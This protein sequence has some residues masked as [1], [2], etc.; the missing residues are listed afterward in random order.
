MFAV[1]VAFSATVS[2]VVS[3]RL[4]R[5]DGA[6]TMVARFLVSFAI[7]IVILR[8]TDRLARRLLPLAVLWKLSLAFP[9]AAPSR[10][11]LAR[12][13]ANVA[14]LEKIAEEARRHG[15]QT[16][17]ARAAGHILTL[18]AAVEAHDRGT[19]GHSERV[20][21]YTD[22]IAEEL[23]LDDEDRNKLRWAALLHDVGKLMVPADVLNKPAK[24]DH[25]EFEV[26]KQ[27][28]IEGKR[29]VEPL[30]AWL[31]EWAH[32]IEQHHERFDGG[33]YPYGL[34]GTMIARA[35]RI[36]AVADSYEVM[37]ARRP[38]KR[39][40]KAAAARRELVACSGEQFDPAM[41]RAFLQVSIGK[42]RVVA[43]PLA[44]LAQT[45]FLRGI[46]QLATS[47]G[48]ATTGGALVLGLVPAV[49]IAGPAAADA[50]TPPART[51]TVAA[52]E[53][54]TSSDPTLASPTPTPTGSV[55]PTP[56]PSPSPSPEPSPTT[57][58]DPKP[59]EEPTPS[60]EPTPSRTTPGPSASPSPSRIATPT[61][62][63]SPSAGPSHTPTGSPRPETSSTPVP[64]P[65]S[66]G[67]LPLP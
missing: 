61:V 25:L 18:V 23:G 10:W 26:V 33:G 21:I 34:S 63:P 19:R 58:P 20:R 42:L 30:I 24:L 6:S 17:P 29:F 51:R 32:A 49:Q 1:P 44:W 36:V 53:D 28:P 9:T 56:T 2:V 11:K 65:T 35:A 16:E 14:Q 47:A 22:L 31:G 62:E 66:I 40:M 50:S 55:G 15:I 43:G 5:V 67:R 52:G 13:A 41:V 59:S 45:P 37:T 39:P 4:F 54:G 48:A 64:Q 60:P 38:Y 57:S 7:S 8:L 12:E 27:H 3:K 46:E